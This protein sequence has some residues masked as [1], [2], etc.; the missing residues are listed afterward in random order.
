MVNIPKRVERY[1]IWY[2]VS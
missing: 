1:R 2:S